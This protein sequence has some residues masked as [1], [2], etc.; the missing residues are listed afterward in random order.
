MGVAFSFIHAADLHLD[1]PFKGMG[2]APDYVKERL[3]DSTFAALRRLVAIAKQERVDFIVL[4]GDLYDAAD[5]SLRAQLK[6]QRALTEL[7]E[8]GIDVFIVHGNHDPLSG[9]QAKLDVPSGVHVCGAEGV[10]CIPAH[11]R[12]GELV[13]HVYGI[14]YAT[15]AVNQNLAQRFKVKG[16]APFHLAI[17]HANVDG[18][19]SHDN[20]AP[21]QLQELVDSGFQYWALGH[22][23]DRRVLHEYPHVVYAG[24]IQGRSIRETGEKGIYL[25]SVSSSGAIT[26]DFR[27]V[28][29]VVWQ[30]VSVTI[31]GLEREQQLKERLLRS[32]DE[33]VKRSS[34]RPVVMRFRIEGRGVLHERLMESIVV[35]E[36]L[37]ELRE[38]SSDGEYSL[39]T[40]IWPD[41]ISVRSGGLLQLEATAEE[42]GFVGELVRMGIAGVSSPESARDWL[43]DAMDKT[44]SQPKIREW[45]AARS[46]E[47]LIQLLQQA[48]ELSVSLLKEDEE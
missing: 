8:E 27:E 3:R 38:W 28:A 17:L 46:D 23:H 13:A 11:T 24:N 9:R 30:E 10:E 39:D 4:S 42:D 14:S 7:T 37:E 5:R 36:W 26:L 41:A 19:A 6:L 40:W 15:S 35:D 48:M 20:Y 29:D 47:E 44:R 18:N 12:N 21:C 34:G 2:S 33:L 22:I 45:V 16:G 1:S 43:M 25:V 31:D 32:M